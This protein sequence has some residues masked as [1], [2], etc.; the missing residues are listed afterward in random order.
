MPHFFPFYKV[1]TLI[2]YCYEE[3]MLQSSHISEVGAPL[4]KGNKSFPHHIFCVFFFDRP[5]GKKKHTL[6]V[7]LINRIKSRLIT[8]R[9]TFQ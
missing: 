4:P 5:Q 3:E 8:G 2:A 9:K 6:G 1:D 7:Q